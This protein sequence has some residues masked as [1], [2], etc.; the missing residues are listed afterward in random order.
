MRN[1]SLYNKLKVLVSAGNELKWRWKHNTVI[2]GI[3]AHTPPKKKN[4]QN[5]INS[6]A[7]FYF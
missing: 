3:I 4:Q 5:E 1:K 6:S 7:I 2:T